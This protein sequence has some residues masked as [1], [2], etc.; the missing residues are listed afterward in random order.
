MAKK[1]ITLSE[2]IKMLEQ[3]VDLLLKNQIWNCPRCKQQYTNT[4][5]CNF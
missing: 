1:K 4:H 3:N 2:R 5:A